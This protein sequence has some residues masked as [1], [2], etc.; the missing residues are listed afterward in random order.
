MMVPY[1]LFV[2]GTTVYTPVTSALG[3]HRYTQ[4]RYTFSRCYYTLYIPP[5]SPPLVA[6]FFLRFNLPLLGLVCR[7]LE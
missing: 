1:I 6:L 7:F 5:P 3:V 4:Y 2:P